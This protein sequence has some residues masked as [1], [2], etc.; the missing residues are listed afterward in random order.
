MV[1]SH[2]VGMETAL[3]N[4]NSLPQ[5]MFTCCQGPKL[6]FLEPLLFSK[7]HPYTH[8][9]HSDLYPDSSK[10]FTSSPDLHLQIRPITLKVYPFLSTLLFTSDALNVIIISL[11]HC[12]SLPSS[13]PASAFPL[14][15]CNMWLH[16]ILTG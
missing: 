15:H 2:T 7:P 16:I 1:L 6:C 10:I 9:F 12:N 14:A 11:D 3:M 13:S 5:E 4:W 8:D